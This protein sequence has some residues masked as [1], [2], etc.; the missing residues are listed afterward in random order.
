MVLA[1]FSLDRYH[2]NKNL[3]LDT[4]GSPALGQGSNCKLVLVNLSYRVNMG[5]NLQGVLQVLINLHDSSLVTTSVAVVGCCTCVN[6]VAKLGVFNR[7]I[8]EKMVT[9]FRS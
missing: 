6:F 5:A 8:P 2:D 1:R 3:R 7:N 4:I 9:T